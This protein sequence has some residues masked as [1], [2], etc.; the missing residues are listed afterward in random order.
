MGLLG[1]V[2]ALLMMGGEL[3]GIVFILVGLFALNNTELA[4]RNRLKGYAECLTAIIIGGGLLV[5]DPE[6]LSEVISETQWIITLSGPI[7]LGLL[8]VALIDYTRLKRFEQ[9]KVMKKLG[10][11]IAKGLKET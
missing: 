6:H 4:V 8:I 1:V 2:G 11:S 3:I 10:E 7:I 5:S 9:E